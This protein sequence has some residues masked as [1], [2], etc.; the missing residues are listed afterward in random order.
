MPDFKH[1]GLG[2]T[3]VIPVYNNKNHHRFIDHKLFVYIYRCIPN[4][5]QNACCLFALSD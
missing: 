3:S 2:W 4:K 1:I 5:Q